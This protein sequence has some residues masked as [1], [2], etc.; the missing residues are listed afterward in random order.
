[1]K[2][3]RPWLALPGLLLL[4]GCSSLAPF[5]TQAETVPWAAETPGP[6]PSPTAVPIPAGT[7]QCDISELTVSAAL[8]GASGTVGGDLTFALAPTTDRP[9][10]LSGAP[11]SVTIED[12]G[13]GKVLATKYAASS[14]SG[15][16]DS[17]VQHAP[18]VLLEPGTPAATLVIWSNWCGPLED[19]RFVV[20]MSP[21]PA[22]PRAISNAVGQLPRCDD[23][24][25]PSALSGYA[26]R[27]PEVLPVQFDVQ[28]A[29]PATASPGNPLDYSVTL[30][31]VDSR[32]LVL[33]PCPE[34]MESLELPKPPG[35]HVER[36]VL[37]CAALPDQ[38]SPGAYVRLAMRI[39]VPADAPLG[40]TSV[41]WMLVTPAADGAADAPIKIVGH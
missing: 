15:P 11:A 37:N 6:S 36:W 18:P 41:S 30:T 33:Q 29:L 34:Y 40:A 12:A 10:L 9:C 3:P 16:G 27:V 38:I 14:R 5:I 19:V 32:P 23:A 21:D 1:V 4:A 35:P 20:R 8:T 2:L 31:N 22:A 17:A 13:T 28:L 24:S 26:F 25:A 39:D 7:Q